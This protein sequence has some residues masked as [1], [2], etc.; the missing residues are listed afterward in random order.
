MLPLLAL[1]S[2]AHAGG[3]GR[4]PPPFWE[5]DAHTITLSISP[6]YLMVP[7]IELTAEF[8]V[9]DTRS[10]TVFG[11]VGRWGSDPIYDVGGQ[12][13]EY[14]LGD[15][16]DGINLGAEVMY[17]NVNWTGKYDKNVAFGPFVGG[18]ISISLFTVELQGGGHVVI[19]RDSIQLAPLINFTTGISF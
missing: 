5:D 1:F 7:M 9:E 8:R 12:V 14:V 6:L 13:R 3:H 18:K 4:M 10:W 19:D 17:S 16:D 11:G 15:F 2:I